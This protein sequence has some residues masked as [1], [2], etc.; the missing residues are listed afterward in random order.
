MK[1]HMPCG[2]GDCE[3]AWEGNDTVAATCPKAGER[4]NEHKVMRL[5]RRG[6]S[7]TAAMS[8]R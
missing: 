6:A 7:W 4:G 2:L 8:D 1:G 3:I 5:T